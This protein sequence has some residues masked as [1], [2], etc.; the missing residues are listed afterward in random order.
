MP[1]R[2]SELARRSISGVV[3]LLDRPTSEEEEPVGE[4]NGEE[5][6][7]FPLRLRGYDRAVVDAHLDYVQILLD[8]L[9]AQS[10][11]QHAVRRA[12]DTVGEETSAILRHAHDTADEIT[13]RSREEA[14]RRT[15][16]AEQSA[17]AVRAAAEAHASQLADEARRRVEEAEQSAAE[18]RA[19]ADAYVCQLD[20]DADRIWS[21][22]ERLLDDAERISRSLLSVGEAARR[23]FPPEEQAPG[24]QAAGDGSPPPPQIT[25]SDPDGLE[26]TPDIRVSAATVAEPL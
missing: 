15:A 21:E 16:E 19:A 9:R 6:P 10:S 5:R 2:S 13:S 4:P 26:P 23:R 8:D 14:E 3:A 7:E 22:R 25:A 17:A 20:E 18:I 24:E 1:T 11:P 12:I